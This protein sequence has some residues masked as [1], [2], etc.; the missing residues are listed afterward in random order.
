MVLKSSASL[1]G[2]IVYNL[3]FFLINIFIFLAG[4]VCG[5]PGTNREWSEPGNK[6]VARAGTY[7]SVEQKHLGIL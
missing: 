2:Q 4:S 7:Q 6:L 5:I 1:D 3:R